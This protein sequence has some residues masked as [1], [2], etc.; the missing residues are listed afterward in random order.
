MRDI[1][2]DRTESGEASTVAFLG[3]D[4]IIPPIIV[5]NAGSGSLLT[6]KKLW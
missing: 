3:I 5:L 1:T 4:L 2:A 6:N